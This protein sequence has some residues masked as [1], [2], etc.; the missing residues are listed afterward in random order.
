M[1][2]IIKKVNKYIKSVNKDYCLVSYAKLDNNY[3]F[4]YMQKVFDKKDYPYVE[5]INGNYYIP[6]IDNT[7]IKYNID[8]D[9]IEH[10]NVAENRKV[11]NDLKF[12]DLLKDAK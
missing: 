11:L 5:N 2:E 3:I 1:E 10:I 4:T 6:L 8:N 7:Y 12:I 9:T